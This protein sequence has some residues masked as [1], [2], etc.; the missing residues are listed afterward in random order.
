MG[1][2]NLPR[3][4]K[5]RRGRSNVKAMLTVSLD[6]EGVVHHEFLHQGQTVN[7]WYY[8]EVLKRLRE[9]VRR[10]K[11]QLWRNNSWFLHHDNAPAHV[12][13]L[14][15]DFLANTNTIVLPRPPYSPDLAPADFFLFSKL[16]STLKGRRFQTIQ[17]ILGTLQTELRAFPKM[18]TRTVSRSGNCFGSRESM[19]EGSTLKA[20][21]LAQLQTCPQNIIKSTAETFEQ[22]TYNSEL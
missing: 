5:E 11:P 3:P 8:L 17:E 20:V 6:T 4:K 9:N 19:Q 2:K 16:N 1:W 13:L 12:S 7:R 15:R 22:T 21:R 18:R 14:I 10:K